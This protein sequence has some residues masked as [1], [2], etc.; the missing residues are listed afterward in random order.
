MLCYKEF[1]VIDLE[2]MKQH[3]VAATEFGDPVEDEIAVML[4]HILE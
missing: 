3:Q 1:R 2:R 4:V